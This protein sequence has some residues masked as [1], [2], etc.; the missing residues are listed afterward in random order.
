[1][2]ASCWTTA[3]SRAGPMEKDLAIPSICSCSMEPL[4][5]GASL[6]FCS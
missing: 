1:L 3:L 2:L 4:W 5:F 6:A